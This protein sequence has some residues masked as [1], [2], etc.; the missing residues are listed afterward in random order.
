ML[1]PVENFWFA[2]V[3][4]RFNLGIDFQ[5]ESSKRGSNRCLD[6]MAGYQLRLSSRVRLPVVALRPSRPLAILVVETAFPLDGRGGSTS[7]ANR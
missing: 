2:A 3:G 7:G 4:Q 6:A 5:S 1:S